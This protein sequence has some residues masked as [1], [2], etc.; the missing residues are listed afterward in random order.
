M[1]VR[2]YFKNITNINCL[3]QFTLQAS[4]FGWCSQK[5]WIFKTVVYINK[6]GMK[7]TDPQTVLLSFWWLQIASKMQLLLLNKRLGW[8]HE[9]THVDVVSNILCN[10]NYQ[11]I[12]ESHRWDVGLELRWP[13]L[14]SQI[15]C[16]VVQGKSVNVTEQNPDCLLTPKSQLLLEWCL[17]VHPDIRVQGS[18]LC[19]MH[20]LKGQPH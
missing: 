14:C 9:W 12:I 11:M 19:F 15:H 17:E 1:I 18:G 2:S 3:W 13:E 16:T 5:P 10:Y 6:A 20:V 7:H 4:Q 8:C